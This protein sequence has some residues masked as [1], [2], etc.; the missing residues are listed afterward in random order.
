MHEVGN[1]QQL[2]TWRIDY[3]DENH[4]KGVRRCSANG[5][6]SL[7]AD[8]SIL[9]RTTCVQGMLT[10]PLLDLIHYIRPGPTTPVV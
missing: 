10:R 2:L 4:L 3:F 7:A 6:L 8:I 5:F 1:S 9:L